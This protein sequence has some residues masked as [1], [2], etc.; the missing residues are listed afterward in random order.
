[1]MWNVAI[2]A[3]ATS[4]TTFSTAEAAQNHQNA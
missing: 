1:L 2:V 4:K 3:V